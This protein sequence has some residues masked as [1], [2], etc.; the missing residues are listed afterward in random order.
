MNP[1][2]VRA[3]LFPDSDLTTVTQTPGWRDAL[4]RV[5][6]NARPIV[7]RDLPSAVSSLLGLDLGQVLVTAWHQHRTLLAAARR[8]QGNPQAVEL[9]PLATHQITT[10]HRPS[11]EIVV[12]EATV[13]T[14][15][16][17]LSLSLE[18]EGL[19]G[20]V[21]SGH[22]VGLQSGRC[23]VSVA[24]SVEE[25]EVASRQRVA[26]DPVLMVSLGEGIALLPD[27]AATESRR[28]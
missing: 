11:V 25:Q 21:R 17:E 16:L 28:P 26:L 13:L 6:A 7:G 22:L 8:T 15:H 1:V 27:P 5:P 23:T 19:A 20:V 4:D 3:V 2:T 10:A 24:L 9:V 18:I 12:N 14:I